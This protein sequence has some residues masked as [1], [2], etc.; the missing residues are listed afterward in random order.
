[1]KI[2]TS[3]FVW[4]VPLVVWDL[5]WKSFALWKSAK[6]NHLRWFVAICILN[7]VG[8]LPMVY[9]AWFDKKPR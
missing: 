8:I 6:N 7:T 3:L 1:M 2:D 5:A 9:L 4:L